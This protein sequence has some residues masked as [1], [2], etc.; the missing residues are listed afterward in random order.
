M[1]GTT[2]VVT[3]GTDGIGAATALELRRRGADVLI[4]G[5]S[6]AKAD[7]LLAEAAG[8]TGPGSM[9]A[10]PTDLSLMA[11]VTA[12]ARRIAADVEHVDVLVQAA[13]IL[14]TRTE[15]TSEGIERDFAVGYLSR[16]VLLET[17]A[18]ERALRPS[19]R[20][21][22]IAAS[23]RTVPSFARLEFADPAVVR[24][25]TGM[26]SHGQAQLANDLLTAQAADRYGVTAIGFGPGSVDTQIRR[27]V[28]AVVRAIMK[29]F[30]ARSTRTPAAVGTQLADI[31]ADPALEPGATVFFDRHG[32]FPI[33]DFIADPERQRDLLSVS[34]LLAEQAAAG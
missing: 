29:P 2:A 10:M 8:L 26:T 31:A 27:E 17:L 21:I 5:R 16:F 11:N 28:P 9:R 25:R 19:T 23:S 20:A 15:H 4:L 12:V 34:L 33:A 6:Q 1:I 13:G 18:E 22:T 14:L 30:F 7:R 3:G 32:R 24:A